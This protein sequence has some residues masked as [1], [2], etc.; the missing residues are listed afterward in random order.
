MILKK[1]SLCLL[2]AVDLASTRF[3]RLD[4]ICFNVYHSAVT[5]K[6]LNHNIRSLTSVKIYLAY[7]VQISIVFVIKFLIFIQSATCDELCA[8]EFNMNLLDL[9]VMLW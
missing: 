3:H 2:L 8:H 9:P 5:A 4:D 1:L 7:V 6:E